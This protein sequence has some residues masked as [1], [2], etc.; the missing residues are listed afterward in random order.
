MLRAPLGAKYQCQQEAAATQDRPIFVSW[1]QFKPHGAKQ[2]AGPLIRRF[3]FK[4]RRPKLYNG[5]VKPNLRSVR[6]TGIRGLIC[7][8]TLLGALG[9][10]AVAQAQEPTKPL[11]DRDGKPVPPEVKQVMDLLTAGHFE[12]SIEKTTLALSDP[13]TADPRMR[14][15]R[16]YAYRSIGRLDDAIKDFEPLGDFSAWPPYHQTASEAAA[17]LRAIIALRP[18]HEEVI[19]VADKVVFRVFYGENTAFT[20]TVLAALPKGYNAATTFLE[21]G[22]EETPVFIFSKGEYPEFVKF[23]TAFS[24]PPRSFSRAVAANETIVIS[25][26]NALGEVYD[27]YA[28]YLPYIVAHEMA[29]IMLRRTI[30]TIK[31]LP[32]WFDEGQATIVG[33]VLHPRWNAG[34]DLQIQQLLQ[35]GQILPLEEVTNPS[36]FYETVGL[37]EEGQSKG[38]PYPQGYN[39]TRYLGKILKGGKL[40]SF[41]HLVSDKGSFNAAVKESTSLTMPEFYASW[42]QSVKD[43]STN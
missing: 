31:D 3:E 9:F 2:S 35:A 24:G 33:S 13:A 18:P 40:S 8:I 23:L 12:E 4:S 27:S 43:A 28:S 29:H 39:M 30:G 38:D 42:L 17:K 6:Q 20:R 5:R 19:R 15:W 36:K 32:T 1:P 7:S 16:G 37:H 11:M 25:Q 21:R 41:L 34:N 14:Y 26:R 22:V 10:G